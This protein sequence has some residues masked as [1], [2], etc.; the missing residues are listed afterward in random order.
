VCARTDQHRGAWLG[1]TLASDVPGCR[2]A[3]IREVMSPSRRGDRRECPSALRRVFNGISSK[4]YIRRWPS[5][6]WVTQNRP[7]PTAITP[8]RRHTLPHAYN[9]APCRRISEKRATKPSLFLP[10]PFRPCS[11][12]IRVPGN[13][14]AAQLAIRH[15]NAP[16]AVQRRHLLVANMPCRLTGCR[17]DSLCSL[18]GRISTVRPS[19]YDRGPDT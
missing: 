16:L 10:R 7:K 2:P 3:P 6:C 8:S 14:S 5:G 1:R 18:N 17:R 11:L 13:R 9:S 15:V 4:A 12:S 19:V